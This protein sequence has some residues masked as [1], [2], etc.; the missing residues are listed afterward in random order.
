MANNTLKNL[1]NATLYVTLPDGKTRRASF[2][3][4]MEEY[5]ARHAPAGD[6]MLCWQVEPSVVFGRNQVMAAEVNTAYC[7]EH[8][9]GMFRRKSGGGC[10]YADRGN[11]M[12]AFIT[13]GD[14]VGLTFN[15]YLMMLVLVL[16]QMGIPAQATGRND[17][18]VDG[19]KVS[20]SAFYHLLGRSI[21]HGTM[22]YDTDMDNMVRALTPPEGKLQSKGVE[23]VRRRIG[24]L[25]DYTATGT[26]GI[27]ESIRRT[28]CSGEYALTADDVA[29]IEALEREEYLAPAFIT[30]K[31]P[32]H[33]LVRRRRIDGVGGLEAYVDVKGGVIK[34]VRLTGDFFA[35]GDVEAML[36]RLNGVEMNREA[37]STALPKNVEEVIMNL[38]KDELVSLIAGS[39]P[40]PLQGGEHEN[41]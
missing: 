38:N 31:D 35:T 15:R 22:L 14:N 27:V 9:I 10:I 33:T 3:L 7:Q 36:G 37:V 16:R 32:G 20:G 39:L 40:R 24:L 2:Y 29:R 26:G 18:E 11:V 23:S 8:G 19:R 6:Y 12:T 13:D 41:A 21:V 1:K 25:K 34:S 28:L 17:I 5:V 4:A 30:G